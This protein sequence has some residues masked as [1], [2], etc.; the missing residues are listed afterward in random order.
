M[1]HG[2]SEAYVSVKDQ[3]NFVGKG[4][5]DSEQRKI[6]KT[7]RC[8]LEA[9]VSLIFLLTNK[10]NTG[11]RTCCQKEKKKKKLTISLKFNTTSSHLP[12]NIYHFVL[13]T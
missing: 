5:N 6:W 11:G 12:L 13:I 1:T 10:T 3:A 4:H 8:S 9:V 2:K 7:N